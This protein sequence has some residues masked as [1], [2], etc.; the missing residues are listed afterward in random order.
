[1]RQVADH[2]FDRKLFILSVVWVKGE[3]VGLMTGC[4]LGGKG[5]G[6][7]KTGDRWDSW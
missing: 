4:R 1:M 6:K 2:G 5:L 3:G 7:V